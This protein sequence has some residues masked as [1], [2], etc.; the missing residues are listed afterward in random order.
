MNN[1]SFTKGAFAALPLVI[2]FL[3]VGIAFGIIAQETGISLFHSVLMSSIVY[4]G[5]SQFMM[6][7]MYATGSGFFEIIL[8]TFIINF[9]FFVMSLSLNQLFNEAPK[10]WKTF[11]AIGITDETFAV[12][13]IN[14][15]RPNVYFLVGLF[16]TSY[17]SWIV[18]TLLGA[19]LSTIIP[20]NISESMSIALYALF[21]G[22]LIP[23]V[24]TAWKYGL[25][26]VISMLINGIF[27]GW[28]LISSGWSMLLATLLV[29][30][31]GVFIFKGEKQHD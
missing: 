30:L 23:A 15:N 24:R 31:V 22:L 3:P 4:G 19:L 28:L 1:H 5:A 13:S 26:A 21:I 25:L 18:G 16:L 8:A 2:G 7:N 20:S 29:S 6:L 10:R 11:L 14:N 12:A 27:S 9:R 17:V